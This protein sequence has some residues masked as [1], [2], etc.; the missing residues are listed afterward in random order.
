MNNSRIGDYKMIWGSRTTKDTWY[1]PKEEPLNKFV[2]NEIKRSRNK[3]NRS[4]ILLP[5]GVETMDVLK[6]DID[7][8]VEYED[9]YENIEKVQL[10][11]DPSILDKT[12]SVF[13]L[14]GDR[15]GKGNKYDRE[16]RENYFDKGNNEKNE[17]GGNKKKKKKKGGKN[18][19]K[20]NGG[21][22][23]KNMI[24]PNKFGVHIK[25][26][27]EIQMFNLKEDPEERKNIANDEPEIRDQIKARV[28]EHFYNLYPRNVPNDT[29]AGDPRKWGGYYGPGWCDTMNI[30][31]S[32]TQS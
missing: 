12:M 30:L 6:L 5:R 27:G 23:N 22:S 25:T 32:A 8:D 13:S 4:R 28:I 19:N 3:A 14:I 7:E 1:K 2:C 17:S 18:K 26:F 20:K 31:P 11:E 15:F 24:L 9:D 29:L 10:N 21:K 16:S